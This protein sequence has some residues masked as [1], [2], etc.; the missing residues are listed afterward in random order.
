MVAMLDRQD[1]DHVRCVAKLRILP[2]EPLVTTWCC[3]TEAMYFLGKLGGV[4]AQNTLWALI[5]SNRIQLHFLTLD[6]AQ[7]MKI[8]MDKYHD[9]PMD[10]AD[11]SLVVTAEEL[12]VQKILTLDKDFFVYRLANGSAFDKLL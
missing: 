8:L 12:G 11:A 6:A 1:P 2:N 3:C 5:L 7:Q 10:L 9:L 4:A